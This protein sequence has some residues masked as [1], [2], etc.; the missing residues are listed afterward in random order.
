MNSRHRSIVSNVVPVLLLLAYSMFGSFAHAQEQ[1]MTHEHMH[2]HMHSASSATTP[3]SPST[4]NPL[5]DEMLQLD[6]A[7]REIVSAVAVRDSKRVHAAI[8]SLHGTME[9]TH[10]GVHQGTV[11]LEKNAAKLGTF[12]SMDKHFHAELEMLAV[13]AEKNNEKGLLMRTKKLL[14]GCVQCHAMFR[15]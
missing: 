7:F 12:V 15:K 8:H 2:E 13:D 11:K 6:T 10:E 5:I 3:E 4:G 1:G 14:D 9:R